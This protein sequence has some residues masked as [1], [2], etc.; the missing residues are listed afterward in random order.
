MNILVAPLATDSATPP[1]GD[2][3]WWPHGR[4]WGVLLLYGVGFWLAHAAA[5]PWGG[6]GYYSLWFP[7]AGVR[8]AVLWRRGVR[9]TPAV[10]V[11]EVVAD[12]LSGAV[13][14][15]G[16]DAITVIVSAVRPALAYG[17]AIAAIRWL[18]GGAR[19]AVLA[20]PMP[21]GLAAIVAPIAAAVAALPWSLLR[22]DMSGVGDTRSI[23]LSLTGFAVG[24]LL[25]VMIVAP[26]LLWALGVLRGTLRS[27][28]LPRMSALA[29]AVAVLGSAIA[30]A[31]LLARAEL[32]LQPTPLLLA[33]AWIGLR[34]GRGAAWCA[35]VIV[36]ALVL[37]QTARDLAGAAR[38]QL[39]LGL[40]AV[41]MVGYL[42][43]SFTEAQLRA[44]ADLARRDRLL[45]QAERLK[46]LRAMSVAVIHEIS[47]PITTL[48]IEARHL[49]GLA[50]DA[51][52][53]IAETAALIDRKA[54]A[55]SLLV[56]R[57][58]RFGGRAVDEPSLLPVAALLE[59][60]VQLVG[61][62]AKAARI[63]LEVASCDPDLLV[64]AQEVELGQAVVNLLRNALQAC[65]DGIVRIACSAQAGRVA[66]GVTN[67]CAAGP[68]VH[69]GMGVGLLVSRA[70]VEAHGG[71]LVRDGGDGAI[72]Y[73]IILPLAGDPL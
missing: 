35:I 66:I 70:I 51:S 27:P 16:A 22:P 50:A 49:H 8:F 52:P 9:I 45:F 15:F 28:R 72:R 46:T 54:A 56:R 34:F 11:V 19:A 26:A 12:I 7:A 5:L 60:V 44:Q 10:A 41:T 58:R 36:A 2:A 23:V 59:D 17:I 64:L 62:E 24:D 30:M 63:R 39:H 38:L 73:Q 3:R 40:A 68:R 25:G 32:G 55:L 31:L 42:A 48:A 33:V 20:P 18:A 65:D 14:P 21:F 67:R 43:G 69:D 6:T 37:P 53:E 29:E 4:D 71:T 47:Q 61:P 1:S 13:D 57:L